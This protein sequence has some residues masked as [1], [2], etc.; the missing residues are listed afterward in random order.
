MQI[1]LPY[2]TENQPMGCVFVQETLCGPEQGTV[3]LQHQG[4]LPNP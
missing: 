3:Q 2:T 1:F 4:K